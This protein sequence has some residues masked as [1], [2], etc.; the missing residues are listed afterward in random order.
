MKLGRKYLLWVGII[1]YTN[2]GPWCTVVI[3]ARPKRCVTSFELKVIRLQNVSLQHFHWDT[4]FVLECSPTLLKTCKNILLSTLDPWINHIFSIILLL[5]LCENPKT[6][7]IK[8]W[9][10]GERYR[11]TGPLVMMVFGMTRPGGELMT[12]RVRGG[13]AN[14]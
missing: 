3:L 4:T 5:C 12:Y 2:E 1:I 14:H 7:L 6:L 8:F 13:H 11:P 9:T 10:P